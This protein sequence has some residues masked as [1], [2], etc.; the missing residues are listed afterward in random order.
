MEEKSF[1]ETLKAILDSEHHDLLELAQIA[2]LDIS[3]DFEGANLSGVDLANANLSNFNLKNSNLS[4]SILRGVNLENANV[5]GTVFGAGSGLLHKQKKL[6][7]KRGAV[8][9]KKSTE[10]EKF[11][12]LDWQGLV[13]EQE[14]EITLEVA[15]RN[16]LHVIWRALVY[17]LANARQGT[18]STKTRAEVQGGG[19]KPWRQKGTGRAR[20]GSTRSPLWRGGGVAFGPKPRDYR[21]KMNKKERRLALRTAFLFCALEK[22]MVVV[23]DFE[24][25][26]SQP[27]TRD[28]VSALA[29][30]DIKPESNVLLVLPEKQELIYLSTRNVPNVKLIRSDQLNIQDLLRCDRIVTTVKGLHKIEETYS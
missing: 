29:R 11:P 25:K 1:N 28:F 26:F 18:A 27:K 14:A 13:T 2:G 3:K 20:A 10:A 22:G 24:Q 15:Q 30:W 9:S 5:R 19:R 17:Q 12:V 7:Q 6:L 8:F 23:D 21:K 16:A 4:D